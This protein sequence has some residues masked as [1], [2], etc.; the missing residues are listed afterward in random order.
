MG[1][2]RLEEKQSVARRRAWASR[3]KERTNYYGQRDLIMEAFDARMYEEARVIEVRRRQL[4]VYERLKAFHAGKPLPPKGTPYVNLRPPPVEP[5]LPEEFDDSGTYIHDA[6]VYEQYFLAPDNFKSPTGPAP[7]ARHLRGVPRAA[8][9]NPP[10]A[11]SSRT[12][13]PSSKP[14]R[15]P[16]PEGPPPELPTSR[17]KSPSEA[18]RVRRGPSAPPSR[19]EPPLPTLEEVKSMKVAEL[20]Q[21]LGAANLDCTGKKAELVQRL[22]QAINARG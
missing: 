7:P 10:Y 13:P 4:E 16:R 9:E 11:P 2:R 12:F 3:E 14:L 19:A 22:E 6:E 21:A 5:P 1:A 8:W 20:K 15:P 18:V 17:K